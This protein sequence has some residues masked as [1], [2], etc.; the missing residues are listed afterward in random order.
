MSL[1]SRVLRVLDRERVEVERQRV[2]AASCHEAVVVEHLDLELVRQLA[3]QRDG[4]AEPRPDRLRLELRAQERVLRLRVRHL[5]PERLEPLELLLASLARRLR[6]RGIDVVG[7]ELERA[8]L[9]VLLA[10]EDE[11]RR[12]REEHGAQRDAVLLGREAIADRAV[13]YLVVVLRAGDE[14]R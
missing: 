7:E 8:R 5:A 3:P 11:R 9:A 6:D 4:L 1:S 14:A 12:A 10:H 13:A 2:P